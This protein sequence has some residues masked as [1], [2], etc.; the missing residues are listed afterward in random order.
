MNGYNW[1]TI[2][3]MAGLSSTNRQG[4]SGVGEIARPI[5]CIPNT[6]NWDA[7]SLENTILSYLVY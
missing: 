5:E 6:L 7:T 2:T 3:V 4:L 1:I